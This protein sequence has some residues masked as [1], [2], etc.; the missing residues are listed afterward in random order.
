MGLDLGV[1]SAPATQ[2]LVSNMSKS[3]PF[4]WL[5]KNATGIEAAGSILGGLGSVYGAYSQA[6]V[7][8][9]INKINK[10]MYFDSKKRQEDADNS[11]KLGFANSTFSKGA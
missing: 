2:S 1:F 9:Q 3:K 8:N 11:L 7:S 10:S 5:T 4:S 6:K